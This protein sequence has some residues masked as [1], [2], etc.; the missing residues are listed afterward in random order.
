MAPHVRAQGP[1]FDVVRVNPK[2][3][4]VIAGRA[5][6]GATVIILDGD[7]E[8]GRVVADDHG[9][10]VYVPGKPLSPGKRELGLRMEIPG[11]KPVL[12][13]QVVMLMVP[14]RSKDLAGK[15]ARGSQALALMMP[16][17][18][19]GPSTILQKPVGPA[20]I[21][22]P[23]GLDA[24]EYADKGA[25][26][27][28]ALSG[29]ADTP[30]NDIIITGHAPANATVNVYLNNAFIGQ[31][32]ADANGV[33]RLKP[34][35]PVKPGMYTLR[36]DQVDGGGKVLARME[37]PFSRTQTDTRALKPGS[38][39]V[40]QPGNSLWRL[41]RRTYGEGVLYSTIYQANTDQIKDPNL[42]Y[43]G[44][45]FTLPETR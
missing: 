33:W 20:A 21:P 38:F 1:T 34:A 28:I 9:E 13:D 23:L 10:W 16:R 31:V 30:G 2:G 18:G 40:V 29:V 35:K 26:K 45:V 3:D 19:Q 36:I 43:P 24:V 17:S 11:K 12:S 42:I 37:F 4:A 22:S 32:H 41:A 8:I 25:D 44:Q 5:T 6:P 14:E 27:T 15:D 39:V 7:T